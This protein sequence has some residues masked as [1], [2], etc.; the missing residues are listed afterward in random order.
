MLAPL[1]VV[2]KRRADPDSAADEE[3][4]PTS[5]SEVPPPPALDEDEARIEDSL[6]RFSELLVRDVMTPRPDVVAIEGT[7][8]V[9]D[10]R[11]VFREAKF[12][13]LPVFGDNLDDIVGVV[14]VHDLTD[15][16]GDAAD[17]IKPLMRPPL[18]V[19]ETKKAAELLK[20]FQAKR[21]TFAVAIDEYGG[22]A[23]VVSVEDIVEELVGEIKDEYDVETEPIAVEPDG[24]VLVAGRVNLDRLEQALETPLEEGSDIG[25][26]GGLVTAVFGRIPKA[27]EKVDYRGFTVEVVDAERKRV[28]RV[29]FRRQGVEAGA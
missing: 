25:T 19:P 18:L 28:N 1:V 6:M 9:E 16:Q 13:R 7:A 10:L 12:S 21:T 5:A 3:Q 29:R 26:V 27:G 11:R 2:L 24:A 15:H 14:T 20:E 17:S 23:G 22:T 8:S 4:T